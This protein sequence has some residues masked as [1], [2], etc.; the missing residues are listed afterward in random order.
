M[1]TVRHSRR[2]RAVLIAGLKSQL[3]AKSL[4]GN[5]LERLCEDVSQLV[6]SRDVL[7]LNGAVPDLLSNK[8]VSSG[9]VFGPFAELV[10]SGK[11]DGRLVVLE[12]G[13]LFDLCT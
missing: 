5:A 6:L 2:R 10:V 13:K 8:E 3:A 1:C 12:D 11:D 9:H 7:N 4:K